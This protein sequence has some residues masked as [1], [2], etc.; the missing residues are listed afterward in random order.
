MVLPGAF[1]KPLA[2]KHFVRLMLNG[3]P[4]EPFPEQSTERP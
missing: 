1:T 2:G 4:Y 3:F